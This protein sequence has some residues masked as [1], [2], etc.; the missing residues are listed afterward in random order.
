MRFDRLKLLNFKSYKEAEI[1]FNSGVTVI[2]GDNGSGKSTLLDACFFALYGSG[3][4]FKHGLG[5]IVTVGENDSKIELCFTHENKSFRVQREIKISGDKAITSKCILHTPNEI[6]EGS[7]QVGEKVRGILRMNSEAF[8]NCA[9]VRQGDNSLMESSNKERQEFIDALLQLGLLQ[10]Y[11]DRTGEALLGVRSIADEKKSKVELLNDHIEELKEKNLN[12]KL[13]KLTKRENEISKKIQICNEKIKNSEN[14]VSMLRETVRSWK[15]NCE[16]RDK[17]DK[18][19]EKNKINLKENK[20]KLD[21]LKI[22]DANRNVSLRDLK[23]KREGFI[24]EI[25]IG[26]NKFGLEGLELTRGRNDNE[27]RGVDI[28]MGLLEKEIKNIEKLLV[29]GK[30]I[31]CGQKVEGEVQKNSLDWKEKKQIELKGKREKINEKIKLLDICIENEREIIKNEEKVGNID[32]FKDLLNDQIFKDDNEL[33]NQF[34][35]QEELHSETDKLKGIEVIELELE[36]G[37]K[38][39]EDNKMEYKRLEN[40]E[41]ILQRN[42]GFAEGELI[43]LG[44]LTKEYEIL[45]REGKIVNGLY[46]EVGKLKKLYMSLR[47][48]LRQRNLARLEI[49][50]NEMFQRVYQNDAYSKIVIDESYDLSIYQKD[51]GILFPSQLSGGEESLI[52]LSLRAAIYTLLIEGIE[53]SVPMP[54]LILDEP[55][56]FLDAGHIMRLN[57]LIDSMKDLGVE[58]ILIVT[59]NDGLIRAADS[60]ISVVKDSTSNRSKVSIEV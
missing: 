25:S 37:E 57:L 49:L 32:K 13:D 23:S 44:K 20:N 10:K 22:E 60:I 28:E 7:K 31:E 21:E 5:D 38:I 52:N 42:K 26:G 27:R 9:Y 17:L 29:E 12:E 24:E 50:F 1:E 56:A 45:V 51:G 8:V 39:I 4:P 3:P 48:E 15:S 59:H 35:Q 54:P 58:Q 47:L 30:C 33:R 2:H 43:R 11:G 40:E 19:I 55:T 53:G 36:K 6:I 41:K 18:I 46:D 14:E 16:E 34:V